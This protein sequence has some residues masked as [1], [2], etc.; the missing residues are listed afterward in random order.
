[1][2]DLR[3]ARDEDGDLLWR[4]HCT[5]MRPPVEA[6]WGWDEALQR[7]YFEASLGEGS[8]QIVRVGGADAGVL[9]VEARADHV[10][11]KTIALLPEFQGRG[12]GTQ[13]VRRVID[14][15]A[16]LGLPVRLQVLKANRARG[17][18]ERLGFREYAQTP[19]HVQM[20][21]E[22]GAESAT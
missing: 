15:A 4:I 14:Q 8:R 11:L 17:L 10:F 1:M 3:P 22:K 2:I 20:V 19:T 9:S 21:R 6:T 13:V 7:T 12:I 18:Y 5:S 16:G